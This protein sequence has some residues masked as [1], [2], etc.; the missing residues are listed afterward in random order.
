MPECGRA[1]WA[2]R[3]VRGESIV[4]VERL[5]DVDAFV[6]F[7]LDDAPVSAGVVR[8]APKI[9]VDGAT[10]L[11]RT[12][13]YQFASFGIQAGGASAGVNAA[14]DSRPGAIES[15][16]TEVE[17]WV[18]SKRFVPDAAKGV[19][20]DDLVA[21]R[22]ADPRPTAFWA[23]G[24]ATG[25]VAATIVASAEL[26]TG[27]LDGRTVAI[28]GFDGV[29]AR[30]A[31]ELAARGACL[32]AIG[33]AD[34]TALQESGF[35]AAAI[36]DAWRAHGTALVRELALEPGPAGEVLGV[37]ADVLIAG[38]KAGVIDHGVAAGCSCRIVVPSG[39]IPVTAKGL[40]VLRREGVCVLPDFV[41]TAGAVL[42]GL[43][44]ALDGASGATRTTDDV[45]AQV[46][47]ALGEVLDHDQ[48]PLLG[49]CHRAESF[50]RTWRDTLP[51]GRP[52]A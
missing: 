15:F 1:V 49:A 38:S 29:G 17:P 21:L 13:T 25:L 47:G 52:L 8:S 36:A 50:L 35:D 24:V 33:T 45:S 12:A 10:W 23:D 39:P 14:P 46:R 2:N 27:G 26:A 6:V 32:V 40:A 48:G 18:A 41:T 5:K 22:N 3:A 43:A 11:A 7:D 44:P 19:A 4:L 51:F 20:A 30:V 31:T 28:E 34:G 37:D 42:G 16:V 9:L